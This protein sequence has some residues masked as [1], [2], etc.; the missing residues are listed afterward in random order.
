MCQYL[1]IGF[2]QEF[3]AV[4][5]KL[6]LEFK[7]I[8]NNTVVDHRNVAFTVHVRMRILVR[9]LAV[10]RPPRMR[11][12]ECSGQQRCVVLE[13]FDHTLYFVGLDVFLTFG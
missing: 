13:V 12:A 2:R 8:F 7:I 10:G 3:M 4:F 6:F 5:L 9:G 1:R 11:D